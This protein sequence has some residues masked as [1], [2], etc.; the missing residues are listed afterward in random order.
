MSQTNTSNTLQVPISVGELFDK[1]TILEIK[2]ERIS[3]EGKRTNVA[4][5][6]AVLISTASVTIEL[7][8][9]GLRI[10][11]ALR[12]VNRQLW[13]IEDEIRSYERNKDFGTR[14]VELARSVY[15]RND[16]R[17]Q[18]KK[19]LNEVMGSELVEE[20]SYADYRT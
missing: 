8:D 7:S 12:Q 15:H 3:D 14:F 2:L 5:E 17:S 20:K 9:E 4:K 16:Q 10:V 6:L 18:H 11:D 19:R 13:D 1:I